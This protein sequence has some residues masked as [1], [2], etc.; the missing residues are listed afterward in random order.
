[1]VEIPTSP[2]TRLCLVRHGETEWNAE[3]RIQGQID[4]ELN[5][6]G[7]RQA[8][9]AGRWL[10]RAGLT[11]L[12]SSDL[13]RAWQ[14]AQA[15]GAATGLVPVA[16]PAL[17]ERRYGIFE[18]LTYAELQARHPEGYAAFEARDVDY[19]F[20]SGESL[21]TMYARVTGCL[22]EIAAAHPGGVV[23][24][25]LHGGVLD[26]VNRF[27]RGTAL[28]TPRDFLIPN[29]GLNWISCRAGQWSLDTWGDTRH[30]E[31]GALDEL[32]T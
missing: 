1:M 28:E 19:D 25:V 3:R 7:L 13:R 15:I 10:A 30:L 21:K 5:A 17:R 27:V 9:A 24:L 12:Y 11:A 26:I 18:G 20:E 31:S 4:I 2:L 29:A 22:G 23:A 16:R 14:T 32:P 8:E 6:T